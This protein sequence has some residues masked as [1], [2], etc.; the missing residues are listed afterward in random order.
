MKDWKIREPL[1][2]NIHRSLCDTLCVFIMSHALKI[3]DVQKYFF[4][5]LPRGSVWAS[6][7]LA[8]SLWTECEI[9]HPYSEDGTPAP[10]PPPKPLIYV[11]MYP[12]HEVISGGN[13]LDGDG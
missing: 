13:L 8:V 9:L 10:P 5:L 1:F 4:V 7:H 12:S 11:C 2:Q 3:K 6:C